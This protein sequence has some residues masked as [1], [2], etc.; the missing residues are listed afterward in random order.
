MME[1]LPS[2]ARSLSAFISV[3]NE[4]WIAK[5]L[6]AEE[7]PAI[8]PDYEQMFEIWRGF[9]GDCDILSLSVAMIVS[10]GCMGWS[11]WRSLETCRSLAW[12]VRLSIIMRSVRSSSNL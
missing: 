3:V 10:A 12:M 8:Q 6:K 9:A 1:V 5:G 11:R 7:F 4:L 2:A